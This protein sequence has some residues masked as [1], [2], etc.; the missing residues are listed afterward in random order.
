[1]GVLTQPPIDM[2]RNFSAHM[3][4]KSKHFLFVIRRKNKN[5]RSPGGQV[6]GM[7]PNVFFV[8]IIIFVIWQEERGYVA[9]SVVIWCNVF[10]GHMVGSL[11]HLLR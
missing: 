5:H 7:F 3:S 11:A 2:S 1:M 4:G 6:R 10:N 9:R 8:E